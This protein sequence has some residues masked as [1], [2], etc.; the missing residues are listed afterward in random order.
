MRADRLLSLL[1]LL[2]TRGR[3]T[4]Q[5]LADELEVSVRT[6]YRDLEALSSA[7]VP[8]YADPGPGGGCAL[9]DN[10][11]TRLTG[12]HEAEVQALFMASMPAALADLGFGADLKTALLKLLAALPAE[13]QHHE[14]WVRSRVYLDWE[15]WQ[16][17]S[18][19]ET[20]AAEHAPP[21]GGTP[22]TPALHVIRRAIWEDRQLR[23]TYRRLS[24]FYR[25]EFTRLVNPY[26]LV[27]KE[28]EWHLMCA[29]ASPAGSGRLRVFRVAELA[30]VDAAEQTFARPGDFDLPRA[31]QAWCS[32]IQRSEAQ[33]VVT[34]QVS[35]QCYADLPLYLGAH[36]RDA[37]GAALAAQAVGAG[38]DWQSVTLYFDSLEEAR[39][40]LLGL[41][42]GVE[43]MTPIAL[44]RSLLDFAEQV[45]KRYSRH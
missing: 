32:R 26:G 13:R 12:L 42:A 35:P 2:Q 18:H 7:G 10:Y 16:A 1:L 40:K 27:A 33:Y 24:S 21:D 6:I 39:T 38:E 14:Q 23:L 9:L 37:A 17:A 43:V 36:L 29:D 19:A 45:V 22:V 25:R 28:G 3:M 34:V 5:A 41:G 11:R 20:P 8:V 30:G 15:S 44:R 4:A 31:W